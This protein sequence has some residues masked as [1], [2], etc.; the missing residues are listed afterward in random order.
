MSSLIYYLRDIAAC[1]VAFI[2]YA[3]YMSVPKKPLFLAAGSGT[4][5]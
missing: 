1:F 4:A 5:A 2:F 3:V